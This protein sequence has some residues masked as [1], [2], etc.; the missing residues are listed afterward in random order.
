MGAS[1]AALVAEGDP[2]GRE[3]DKKPTIN[4]RSRGGKR[5]KDEREIDR[6][7]FV[8]MFVCVCECVLVGNAS[9]TKSAERTAVQRALA[10]LPVT[11]CR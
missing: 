1:W 5:R 6:G 11:A 10:F 8:S 7:R 9:V 4:S 3:E 2:Q